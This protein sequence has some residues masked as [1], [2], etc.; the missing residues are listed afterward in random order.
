MKHLAFYYD[1]KMAYDSQVGSHYFSIKALPKDTARQ[2]IEELHITV[3]PYDNLFF[4][5]DAFGNQ[6]LAGH[7]IR[8][9][10]EFQ[11]LI[12]GKAFVSSEREP[13]KEGENLTLFRCPT[14]LTSMSEEMA[15]YAFRYL[16]PEQIKNGIPSYMPKNA[17]GTADYIMKRLYETFSYEAG[18][19]GIKTTAAEAFSGRRGVCQ[20]YAHIMLAFLRSMGYPCRYVTGMMIG[21]GA[22]HA[23]IEVYN[24][25]DRMWYG[26]DP[27]NNLWIDENYITLARGR[28]YRDC[29]VNKGRFTGY[30]NEIQKIKLKVEEI[31]WSK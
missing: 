25:E 10:D 14:P 23:W 1:T 15:E 18:L 22:T 6:I 3:K 20:D 21:E 12:E 13:W 4:S 17:F 16:Q 27:T 28:D 19:T 8:L 9:H 26:L 30:T 2:S 7:T 5:R 29:V 24:E 31:E 11:V